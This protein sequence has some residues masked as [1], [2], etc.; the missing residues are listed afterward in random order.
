VIIIRVKPQQLVRVE[1]GMNTTL[2]TRITDERP[3]YEAPTVRVMTETEI[4]NT[5]Q[6]TQAMGTWWNNLGSPFCPPGC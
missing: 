6:I 4:L 5:F 2:E 1:D 3:R